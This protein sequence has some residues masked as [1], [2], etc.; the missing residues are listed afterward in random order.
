MR[1]GVGKVMVKEKKRWMLWH[2][3]FSLN[4]KKKKCNIEIFKYLSPL[5]SILQHDNDDNDNDM[6]KQ[7]TSICYSPEANNFQGSP[8]PLHLFLRANSFTV[9]A[10]A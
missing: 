8:P 2:L 4:R 6:L 1:R 5:G 7:P 10:F 9:S 3:E